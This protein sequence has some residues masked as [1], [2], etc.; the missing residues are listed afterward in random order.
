MKFSY[1]ASQPDGKTVRGTVEAPSQIVVL[2]FLAQRELRP[3]SVL[4]AAISGGIFRKRITATDVI[5]LTKYLALMLRA[6]TDLFRAL[7]IL[8]SDFE[9]PAM[10]ALLMEIRE[11]LERGQPF[12]TTFA[13]YPK[14]FE[15]VFVNLVKAGEL[16]GNL[17]S[18]FENLSVML[19]K[20]EDLRRRIVS[21]LT[22]PAILFIAS[23]GIVAFL[24]TFALP[25]IG[26]VFQSG[27]FTPP[28][29]VGAVF[30]V[31]GFISGNIIPLSI[32]AFGGAL[33]LF[34]FFFRTALGH[35]YLF[36]ILRHVPVVR[37]VLQR[38]AIQRFAST[39]SSLLHAGLPIIDSLELTATAVGDYSFETALR[40]I[41]REG[42]ARGLTLGDAF[43]R[44]AAFPLVITTLIGVSEKAGHLDEVLATLGSFYD[45]E[46][47]ASIK[48][49]VTLI[50]PLMLIILG[51]IVGLIALSVII[52]IYQLIGQF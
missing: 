16:S 42:V 10:K 20:K 30:A 19:A 50:E 2:G 14:Q 15:P 35:E 5:F 51:G 6:G 22:Y 39:L 44:E 49:M 47:D 21:A 34:F 13:R 17:E 25:R 28:A 1:V 38:I 24:V 26:E 32:A 8:I 9:K 52:P 4:P 43:R 37:G 29:F 11:T 48:N 33:F 23:M 41:A 45:S 3:I 12:Y 27:G 31:A 40:H 46:I 7:D 18:V 36:T